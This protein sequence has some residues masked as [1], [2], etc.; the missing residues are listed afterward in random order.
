MI[1]SKFKRIPEIIRK[2]LRFYKKN[3]L[4][5]TLFEIRNWLIRRIRKVD[6]APYQDLHSYR[7]LIKKFPQRFS[8]FK[9]PPDNIKE[10][11]T[12]IEAAARLDL[13]KLLIY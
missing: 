10:C 11:S 12:I 5:L 3:G 7:H 13:Q 6:P 9:N 2:T 1:I 8:Q 4:R